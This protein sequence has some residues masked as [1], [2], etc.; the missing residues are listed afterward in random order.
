FQTGCIIAG[1]WLLSGLY[2]WPILFWTHVEQH[3]IFG[4]QCMIIYGLGQNVTRQEREVFWQTLGTLNSAANP[5]I[6]FIFNY[7]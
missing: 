7:K 3:R 5:I 6:F 1:S 4:R 2:S